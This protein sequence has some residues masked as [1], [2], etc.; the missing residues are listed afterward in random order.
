MIKKALLVFCIRPE[1]IKMASL[2]KT[3]EKE[4]LIESKEFKNLE[5]E[6]NLDFCGVLN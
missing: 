1:S 4:K 2:V 3:F 6:K 5:I